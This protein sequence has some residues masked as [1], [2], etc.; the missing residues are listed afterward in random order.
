[1]D[2]HASIGKPEIVEP[3][4]VMVS[5]SSMATFK[6]AD[7]KTIIVKKPYKCPCVHCES[8]LEAMAASCPRKVSIR[9]PDDLDDPLRIAKR[10]KRRRV[11]NTLVM[12][13]KEGNIGYPEELNMLILETWDNQA[14]DSMPK[15]TWE[16]RTM[17]CRS[18]IFALLQQ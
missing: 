16:F 4:K 1:M 6:D 18:T 11:L 9:D 7:M 17:S 10:F 5:E 15:R 13:C 3:V 12:K 8:H 14:I 2:E